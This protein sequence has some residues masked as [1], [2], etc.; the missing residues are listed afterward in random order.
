MA[1]KKPDRVTF[2]LHYP[3]PL[4]PQ[5]LTIDA[6]LDEQHSCKTEITQYPVE[7]GV[8]IADHIRPLPEELTLTG[9]VSN[10]P[11]HAEGIAENNQRRAEQFWESLRDAKNKGVLVDVH[12]TLHD[13]LNMGILGLDAPRNAQYGSI[14]RFQMQF[15]EVIT[16]ETEQVAALKKKTTPFP[17]A[18]NAK[19]KEDLGKVV[20]N[21]SK[22][23]AATETITG[24]GI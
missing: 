22:L 20:K 1:E 17:K 12:T 16:T 13:Y 14:L 15:R 8:N 19:K 4:L 6:V 18:K 10:Y 11:T 9:I 5:V 3:A 23:K 21:V 24:G 2:T 7:V